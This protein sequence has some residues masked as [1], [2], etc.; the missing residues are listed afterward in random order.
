[1]AKQSVIEVSAI[2][3]GGTSACAAMAPVN[4]VPRRNNWIVSSEYLA[5]STLSAGS[6]DSVGFG[7]T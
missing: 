1:M 4:G 6:P 3:R 7:T 2:R 5:H